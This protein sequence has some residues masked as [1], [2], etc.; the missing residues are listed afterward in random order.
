MKLRFSLVSKHSI[1][2]CVRQRHTPGAQVTGNLLVSGT[3]T[4]NNTL[5]VNN[6]FPVFN[7]GLQVHGNGNSVILDAPTRIGDGNGPRCPLDV[8]GANYIN[9]GGGKYY[10]LN[11][12]GTGGSG[13]SNPNTPMS[14]FASDRIVT[15]A[16]FNSYSDA[17]I[18]QVIDRSDTAQDLARVRQ[19][20]ITDYRKI[21][22]VAYGDS[23]HKGVLAQE[24]EKVIPEAV[25]LE[26][27]Y[28]PN[29]YTL[30]MKGLTKLGQ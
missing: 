8:A 20:Q 13:S 23:V 22:R 2:I 14:I 3:A 30:A 25:N 24:V 19:L 16:E 6:A 28:I 29:I 18:K 10:Y 27:E 12:G 17:R 15:A 21:D 5:T 1:C 26:T 4:V 9:T 7:R 11:N